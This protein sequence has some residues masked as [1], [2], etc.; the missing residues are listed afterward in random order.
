[1]FKDFNDTARHVNG[2]TRLLNRLRCRI[3]LIRFHPVPGVPYESSDEDTIQWFK[4]R[5]NEK[6]LLTTIRAS[7]G[8]DILAACGMLSTKHREQQEQ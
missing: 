3:N 8:L 2:L 1:M 4:Q 6:G 5:L 7:R